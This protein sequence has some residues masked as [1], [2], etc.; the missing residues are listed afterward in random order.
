MKLFRLSAKIIVGFAL[1]LLFA[2]FTK[3]EIYKCKKQNNTVERKQSQ[4]IWE[5]EYNHNVKTGMYYCITY[6]DNFLYVGMKTSDEIHKRQLLM[7]GL[8]FWID[9]NARG[10]EQLGLT[11][12][13]Q[14]KLPHEKLKERKSDSQNRDNSRKKTKE[15]I[16]NFNNRYLNGLEVMGI[17]GFGGES[18]PSTSYNINEDGISAVLHIDSTDFMYYFACIPLDLVFNEPDNYLNNREEYF[19]FSFIINALEMPSSGMNR[20]RPS[21]GGMSPG[22]SGGGK[23][24]GGKSGGGRPG[25]GSRP[26]MAQ[27]DEM[28][29]PTEFTIKKASLYHN[30]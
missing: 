14:N 21:G 20:D 2:N 29:Q 15:E 22:G 4:I 7:A 27:M 12:P 17:I 25:D 18:E 5:G 24:E 6:D 23:P 19:S 30:K 8:T 3:K 16:I 26:G 11:F 10:K 28:T 9:T 13:I 1:I